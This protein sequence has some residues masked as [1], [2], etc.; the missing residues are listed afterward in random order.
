[1]EIWTRLIEG[2]NLKLRCRC[3]ATFFCGDAM[4]VIFFPRLC[5]VDSP[6]M[7][8]SLLYLKPL[9][10]SKTL[11]H[12]IYKS[13]KKTNLLCILNNVF[14]YS[15][16]R[17]RKRNAKKSIKTEK[18]C[19]PALFGIRNPLSWNP[20]SSDRNP[21][22]TGWNPQSKTVM[23][24]LT[25]GETLWPLKLIEYINCSCLLTAVAGFNEKI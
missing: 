8:P 20:E 22:S 17:T 5:G 6:P 25:W 10:N 13:K 1:M 9:R 19:N 24:S 16:I 12:V 3:F 14:Q 21:E 23:D 2:Q 15:K 11:L 4:F 18:I 7:P